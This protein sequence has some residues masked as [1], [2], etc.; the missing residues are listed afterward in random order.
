[1]VQI[2]ACQRSIDEENRTKIKLVLTELTFIFRKIEGYT[3]SDLALGQSLL[4]G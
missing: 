1:M 4:T 2:S 3:T